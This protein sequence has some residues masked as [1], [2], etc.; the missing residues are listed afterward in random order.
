MQEV[1]YLLAQSEGGTVKAGTED[2]FR[3]P[4]Q[5]LEI[6]R[7]NSEVQ[8]EQMAVGIVY[9]RIPTHGARNTNLRQTYPLEVGTSNPTSSITGTRGTRI[10][11][12]C[13]VSNTHHGMVHHMHQKP[14]PASSL[15]S[16]LE[17]IDQSSSQ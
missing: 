2:S 1:Q 8:A 13:R 7:G 14:S 10:V 6:P 12:P 5:N 17:V 3:V 9:L 4:A 11:A 16:L 15:S